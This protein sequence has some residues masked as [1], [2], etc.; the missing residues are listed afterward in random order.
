MFW[1]CCKLI[2]ITSVSLY[3]VFEQWRPSITNQLLPIRFYPLTSYSFCT[4][5][6]WLFYLVKALNSN[7]H[8]FRT[9]PSSL[10]LTSK[11]KCLLYH[12]YFGL[13]TWTKKQLFL[14]PIPLTIA[15]VPSWIPSFSLE[16]YHTGN[17]LMRILFNSNNRLMSWVFW[18]CI[19]KMVPDHYVNHLKTVI[20]F[21]YC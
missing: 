3:S 5:L 12:V 13:Q 18:V 7:K 8:S 16:N 4:P 21:Y 15:F 9:R 10:W 19:I 11:S 14:G 6:W 1:L 2:Q 17:W 20:I